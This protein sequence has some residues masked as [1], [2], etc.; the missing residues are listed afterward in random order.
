MSD[1]RWDLLIFEDASCLQTLIVSCLIARVH[2]RGLGLDCE[3]GDTIYNTQ[4][5][6]DCSALRFQLYFLLLGQGSDLTKLLMYRQL[7]TPKH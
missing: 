1:T 5:C 6:I 2:V 3:M 4:H 7:Q